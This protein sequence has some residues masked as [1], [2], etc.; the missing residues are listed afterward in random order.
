MAVAA[1]RKDYDRYEKIHGLDCIA[2]GSC[3]FI[4]PAKRPLMQQ[5]KQ[6]KGTILAQ[7]AAARAAAAAK[8]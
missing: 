4:C 2:C 5:F 3:T 8:K 7:K 1:K 6:A